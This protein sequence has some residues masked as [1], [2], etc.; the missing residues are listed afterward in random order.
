MASIIKNVFLISQKRCFDMSELRKPVHVVQAL[1][2]SGVIQTAHAVPAPLQTGY[3]LL[4]SDKK[5]V[6][7]ELESQ[8]G[9]Q[10]V[11]KTL[12][13][14]AALVRKLGLKSLTVTIAT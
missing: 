2:E 13:A 4:F 1:I 11:F 7:A 8:R 10:R 9:E 3:A 12:D 6:I 5:T 14:V